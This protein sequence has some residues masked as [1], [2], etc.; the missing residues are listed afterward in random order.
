[1]PRYPRYMTEQ[2]MQARKDYLSG[3]RS[4]SRICID[5]GMSSPNGMTMRRMVHMHFLMIRERILSSRPRSAFFNPSALAIV[6]NRSIRD[7]PDFERNMLWKPHVTGMARQDLESQDFRPS[8]NTGAMPRQHPLPTS[9]SAAYLQSL[10]YA[11]SYPSLTELSTIADSL[12][13]GID[14]LIGEQYTFEREML[15][16]EKRD[17]KLVRARQC[18]TKEKKEK[19]LKII[20]IL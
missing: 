11:R 14:H 4:A 19:T 12:K 18:C 6:S 20:E 2:K 8:G 17:K 1:M 3:V 15:S 10:R 16:S 13:C 7:V 9:S 5:P